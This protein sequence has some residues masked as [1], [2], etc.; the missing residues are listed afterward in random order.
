[1]SESAN[2]TGRER[3]ADREARRVVRRISHPRPWQ[4][5]YLMLRAIA[6]GLA[7]E[8]SALNGGG[9]MEVLD[10]GCK[11][12][13]YREFFSGKFSR[14]VGVDL[15]SYRGMSAR[16]DGLRLPFLSD[17]FDLLLCTQAFYLMPDFRAALAEFARV[18][19]RG[20]RIVLTT[21]GIWPY[22]REQRLHRW[23]RRELEEA[24]SEIGEARVEETGGYLHLIPQLANAALAMGIERH[25]R[26]EHGKAGGILALPLKGVYLGTNLLS[27]AGRAAIR[28]AAG[29]GLGWA[30]SLNDLDSHLAINYLA[31]VSPRK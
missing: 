10:V 11:Y 20:G 2:P 12:M 9:K 16:A 26:R 15:E 17:S 6:A 18:T 7:R 22:P 8:A 24:L 23:S 27:M 3:A 21:I 4:Y 1:M 31:V 14:Y 13:P 30:R 25:L 5:D 29:A 19:R 28:A